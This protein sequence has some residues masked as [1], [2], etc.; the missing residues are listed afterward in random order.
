MKTKLYYNKKIRQLEQL[1]IAN[2]VSEYSLMQTAGQAAFEKLRERWPQAANIVVCCGKGNNAGD[3]YVVASLAKEHGFAVTIFT[4]SPPSELQGAALEAAQAAQQLDITIETFDA[5]KP[6]AADVIVDA[7]LGSGLQ[8]DV[9]EPFVSAIQ[10]INAS[11]SAVLSLDVPS[12]LDVDTGDILGSAVEANVTVTFIAGK[13]GLYTSKAPAY[14]GHIY[15][16]DLN[17]PAELFSQITPDAQ[18]IDWEQ[19]QQVLPRRRKDAHKGNHGHV[20]VIGGDYGMGGAVRMAAEA[21]LRVGAGLVSVA[22]RP[23]H[24]PIVSCARPEIMCHQVS[25]SDDLEVLLAK[26]TVVVI[27]PGLGKSEWAEA[28]LATVLKH[29]HPKVLDADSLNLLSEHPLHRNDWVLTPHP[30]EAARLLDSNSQA[31]QDNRFKAATE[32]QQQY[33]GVTVLKGAGTIIQAPNHIPDICM[34]GNPG[35]AT[36]GMG[37]VLS[38]V[39]AGL[40]AQGLALDVA[41][42]AGV[43]VHAKAADLA[44]KKDGERGLLACDLMEH[45]RQ[46]V[47]PYL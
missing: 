34:A 24:V 2:G 41:A 44:A 46:L 12:G 32:I 17:I 27:G 40:I 9:R 38:G 23:E 36:G 39:I 28:L 15:W 33:G 1:A 4:L 13:P 47:N 14:C 18:L 10:A 8:G 11:D 25:Q 6:L 20:L 35:M 37:D 16:H 30:G 5:E 19:V 45:L 29:D 3:G 26:A 7:L 21:A 43:M 42:S 22:T 31:I